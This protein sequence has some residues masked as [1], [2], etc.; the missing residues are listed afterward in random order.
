[1]I[2]KSTR[3]YVYERQN[4]KCGHPS[5]NKYFDI[6][7]PQ[8]SPFAWQLHH[9]YFKSHYKKSDRDEAWN[10]VLLCPK[11]HEWN[12]IDGSYPGEWV[13]NGNTWLRRYLEDLADLWKPPEERSTITISKDKKVKIRVKKEKKPV[14]IEQKKAN[15]AAQKKIRDKS[16]ERYKSTHNWLSPWQFEYRKQKEFMKNRKT[17]QNNKESHE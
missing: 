15:R 4:Y 5:C 14:S 10:L 16:I 6:N 12:D 3:K 2:K 8:W 9:I 17:L 11:H 1:M 7:E 13:H